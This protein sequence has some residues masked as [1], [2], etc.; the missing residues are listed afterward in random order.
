MELNRLFLVI[1][2]PFSFLKSPF[3]RTGVEPLCLTEVWPPPLA[4]MEAERLPD[5]AGVSTRVS[6]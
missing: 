4:V 1:Q 3:A 5:E 6:L 2:I